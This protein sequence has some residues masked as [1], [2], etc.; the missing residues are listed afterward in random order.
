VDENVVEELEKQG[1]PKKDS[2]PPIRA[3]KHSQIVATY[4]LL[5]E[6]RIREATQSGKK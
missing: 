2:I 5:L 6:K 1:Y 3:K 4:R